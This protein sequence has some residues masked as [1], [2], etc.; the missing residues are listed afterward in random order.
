MLSIEDNLIDNW[1]SFDQLSEFPGIKSLRFKGN[2]IV[3]KELGGE[4]ARAIAIAR[5]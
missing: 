2:P 4:N 3:T 1:G 5:V